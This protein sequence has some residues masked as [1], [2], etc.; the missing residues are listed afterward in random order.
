MIFMSLDKTP[1]SFKKYCEKMP[2]YAMPW[3]IKKADKVFSDLDL[4]FLPSLV[5]VSCDGTVRGQLSQSEIK[6]ALSLLP[7]VGDGGSAWERLWRRLKL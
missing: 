4:T 6:N 5:H 3:N 2:W 1:E 7:Q